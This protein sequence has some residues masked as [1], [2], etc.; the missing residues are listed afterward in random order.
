MRYGCETIHMVVRCF[1]M[2]RLL[3]GLLDWH[4]APN[5]AADSLRNRSMIY[6]QNLLI[7]RVRVNKDVGENLSEYRY[8]VR[9]KPTGAMLQFLR[10]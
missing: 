10:T 4:P 6:G 7:R 5:V 8:T 9:V 2:W 1:E 3:S